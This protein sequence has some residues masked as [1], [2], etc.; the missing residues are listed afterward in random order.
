MIGELNIDPCSQGLAHV[1]RFRIGGE[2]Y[3]HR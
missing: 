3:L 2:G 1:Q